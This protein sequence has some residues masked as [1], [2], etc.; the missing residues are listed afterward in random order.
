MQNIRI[1]YKTQTTHRRGMKPCWCEHL[2]IWRLCALEFTLARLAW[3]T[4]LRTYNNYFFT[5]LVPHTPSINL[6]C[7]IFIFPH[8]SMISLES[9]NSLVVN[10]R[11][12]PSSHYSN[13]APYNITQPHTTYTTETH[14]RI[15]HFM[16]RRCSIHVVFTFRTCGA[17]T[18]RITGMA[19]F[20]RVIS[21]NSAPFGLK[22]SYSY[23]YHVGSALE[24]NV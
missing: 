4:L 20:I 12:R 17:L 18:C 5:I 21:T 13:T 7:I 11:N 22:T 19:M 10:G 16:M 2:S 1:H 24:P 3:C 15:L 6:L 14:I 9:L 23:S 8:V